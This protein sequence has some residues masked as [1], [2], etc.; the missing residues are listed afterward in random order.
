MQNGEEKV[1]SYASRLYSTAEQRYCVTRKQLLAVVFFLKQFRQY[2]LGRRF[3]VRTD[4]AALRWLRRTPEPIGQQSRW[5]EV[6]EEFNFTVEHRPGKKHTNADALSRRPCR[7]CGMCASPTTGALNVC[8]LQDGGDGNAVWSLDALKRAQE[9][10]PDIGPLYQAL[11]NNEEK[12]PW[13]T[14]LSASRETKVY[15]TQWNRLTCIDGVIYRRYSPPHSFSETRQ[16]LIPP[17]Y[18][19]EVL[20]QAHKGFTGGHM[21]ERRTLEQVRRRG[22]WLGWA[23]DTRRFCRRCPECCSYKRGTAPKQGPLQKMT[24]GVPWERIGV[25][26]TGPHPKSR[27]GYKYILTV[28]DYFSKWADAFP[29]RNQEAVTVAKVLVD[30]VFSYMGMPIQILTDRGS[31]FESQLFEELLTRLHIDH[32]RTTAYKPST[33]GQVER[34]HRTLNS[35]LGKVVAENQRDWDVHLP[36]AVAAYRAT[37]H[38][39]TGYSPNF[40]MFGH[41]VRPPLDVIM[42]LPVTSSTPGIAVHEFVDEKLDHMRAAYGA[43][44]ESLK[45]AAERQKHHY[46][47]RVKPAAFQPNDSVWLWT[48]R[49]QQGKT[50]KWQRRFVG[51]YVVVEKIGPVNYHIRRSAKSKPFVVHVDKL[52]PYLSPDAPAA[53]REPDNGQRTVQSSNDDSTDVQEEATTPSTSV[54]RPQRTRTLPGRYRD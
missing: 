49:R 37:I 47:L 46:D 3:V 33:N 30:R 44:R 17:A 19:G 38:E 45:K 18:R 35:I 7:Q 36:Y 29:I 21:G 16:M 51:P 42:G 48:T 50:P 23:A 10:D 34:F 27:N 4:H 39:S 25:D 28:T 20:Q 14:I 2:L 8:T 13:E 6:L 54:T 24:V 31:N 22:Y 32:V 5:L 40:L 52:R 15:W 1:I 43:V 53:G 41:E 9:Q 11:A 12:P 26:I